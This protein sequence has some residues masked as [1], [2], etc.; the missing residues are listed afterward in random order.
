MTAPEQG[1]SSP[2]KE[3]MKKGEMESNLIGEKD[4]LEVAV[5][6]KVDGVNMVKVSPIVADLSSG[7]VGG[8]EM[9]PRFQRR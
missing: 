6:A 3:M 2:E 1:V 8:E 5:T 9:M 7:S 4:E